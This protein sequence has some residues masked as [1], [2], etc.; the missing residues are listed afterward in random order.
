VVGAID[1]LVS[2]D[3]SLLCSYAADFTSAL[4]DAKSIP[5]VPLTGTL[6]SMGT[7]TK[8]S[9]KPN[10]YAAIWV[11]SVLPVALIDPY[12]FF[13]YLLEELCKSMYNWSISDTYSDEPWNLDGLRTLIDAAIN[14]TVDEFTPA[15]RLSDT[16]ASSVERSSQLHDEYVRTQPDLVFL[17][18]HRLPWITAAR[19]HLLHMAAQNAVNVDLRKRIIEL[20]VKKED[21]VHA[22]QTAHSALRIS[23]ARTMVRRIVDELRRMDAGAERRAVQI[24]ALQELISQQQKRSNREEERPESKSIAHQGASLYP[25]PYSAPLYPT[26]SS[27]PVYPTPASSSP[28][29]AVYPQMA[30]I[31]SPTP[32]PASAP[33]R[34]DALDTRSPS[35]AHSVAPAG[36]G[37]SK[38][39][40][41]ADLNRGERER[42]N[43]DEF[44]D[45]K[46]SA[47]DYVDSNRKV[48][49]ESGRIHRERERVDGPRERVEAPRER[50]EVS[51]ER[52]EAP[53]ERVEAP[54]E[55]VEAP[56]ERVEVSREPTHSERPRDRDRDRDRERDRHRE[57]DRDRDR[58]RDRGRE[59][60][61]PQTQQE[62]ALIAKKARDYIKSLA[63]ELPPPATA[64]FS[65]NRP[66]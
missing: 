40:E 37:H 42:S 50:V 20:Q 15:P 31:Q 11:P 26:P 63:R 18:Q 58:D 22:L 4:P 60:S 10:T 47:T 64:G 45:S 34:P 66:N 8:S 41:T 23:E 55:R 27:A 56:R 21:A 57:R 36:V 9:S 49:S 3:V 44:R 33:S 25:T 1:L 19:R 51:R 12:R 39:Y 54:R 16:I 32:A 38:E 52:V 59:A 62:Q 43:Q 46:S 2:A 30:A 35:S 61:R 14:D 7:E 17:T 48:T 29:P 24:T 28:L 65:G 5:P 6:P 13:R 53:R